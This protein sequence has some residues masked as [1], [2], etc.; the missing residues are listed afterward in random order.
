MLVYS[1]VLIFF[2]FQNA[3][4]SLNAEYHNYNSLTTLLQNYVTQFPTKAY[5]YSIGK[6]VQNRD[7]W[8]IAISDS[9]PNVHVALRPEAKYIG[10]MHGNE[11]TSKEVLLRFI[12]YLL[13]NQASDSSVDYLLKNTRIHI[14]P[15]MNPDGY[16]I[17][18][19]GDCSGFKGRYNAN[20]YDLNRN[21]PDLFETNSQEIQPETQAVMDWLANN[22]FILSANF[23]SGAIVVNYPYDNLPANYPT[24]YSATQ[25]DKL[26][27]KMSKAYSYNHAFM[28]TTQCPYESFPDGITNGGKIIFKIIFLNRILNNYY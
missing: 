5:L 18:S 12:D 23:H 13:N 21:F 19:E 1:L 2:A 25:E 15:S 11:P 9:Q 17:S 16:E 3:Q 6:S 24:T 28:R 10:N 20:N 22:Q 7:L 27:I 8:V 26:F 4:A 14:M